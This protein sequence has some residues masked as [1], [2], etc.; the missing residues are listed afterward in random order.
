M[1][2]LS[3][4]Y[5]DIA[6]EAKET[7]VA[8][9]NDN[10]F[11][12]LSQLQKYNLAFPNYAN[13]CERYSVALDG[14]SVPLPENKTPIVGLWSKQQSR[15]D[16]TFE[17]PI[18]LTLV[19]E[20][21]F[22]SKG[23]TFTFDMLN[24]VYPTSIKIHWWSDSNGEL[25]DLGE[26]TF[27]PD[28][29]MYFCEN[30]IEYYNRVV[31]TFTGINMPYNRL[32]L[33]AIDYGYG[34]VFYGDE[35]RSV[36]MLQEINPISQSISINTCDFTVVSD[37]NIDYSFT[38]KQPISIYYNGQLRATNFVDSATRQSKNV[39]SIK[40]EDYIGIMDGTPFAGGVYKDK[41]AIELISEIFAKSKVPFEIRDIDETATV[42][43][44]IPYTTCREALMQVLFVLGAVVDTSNLDV[45][46]VYRLDEEVK[47]VIPLSR[48]KPGQKVTDSSTITSVVMTAHSYSEKEELTESDAVFVYEAKTEGFGKEVFVKFSQPLYNIYWSY[49]HGTVKEYS[50][51]HAIVIPTDE[52]FRM[53][54]FPYDVVTTE[55]EKKNPLLVKTDVEKVY[56]VSNATLVNPD[57][58]NA[59][60]ERCYAWAIQNREI[61]MK[62]IEGKHVSGGLPI[63]W[64]DRK[65]GSFKWGEKTPRVVTYDQEVNVGDKL[66][67]ETEY[68]G[69]LEGRVI[70]QKFSYV[71]GIVVKEAT[72]K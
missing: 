14:N 44:Y 42:T 1:N 56:S 30:R 53:W 7:F 54:G 17:T 34:T 25:T 60:L 55:H 6:P 69:V 66:Q 62:I 26:K 61:S 11:D 24:N 50:A 27:I 52:K 20:P 23:L 68:L 2:G 58:V 19:S 33:R 65:W 10:E 32:K 8:E 29:A 22:S 46:S 36:T 45:A 67:T 16:G 49:D 51:N 4:R 21:M 12:S 3:I 39:W 5:G 71:G 64:G 47:Q 57:N 38:A 43:G 35:L 72:L 31:I 28:N 70:K 37:R 48:I 59:V 41:N 18:K 40:S 13:P 63:K 9:V 15:K